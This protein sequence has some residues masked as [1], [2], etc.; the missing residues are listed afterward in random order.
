MD[1]IKY[2]LL[3]S[4]VD[5][6]QQDPVRC[7]TY[8]ATDMVAKLRQLVSEGEDI[9]NL[10]VYELHTERYALPVTT[11]AKDFLMKREG[12]KNG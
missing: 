7:T 8:F 5:Q 3:D 4:S 2:A 1:K 12:K 11:N 6:A 9:G 10:T